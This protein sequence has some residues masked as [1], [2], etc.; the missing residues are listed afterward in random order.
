MDKH[1]SLV[2]NISRSFCPSFNHGFAMSGPFHFCD[3]RK[4]IYCKE[5]PLTSCLYFS[6][7]GSRLHM[8]D[9]SLSNYQNLSRRSGVP[10]PRVDLV[11]VT[12]LYSYSYKPAHQPILYLFMIVNKAAAPIVYS[13]HSLIFHPVS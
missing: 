6:M 10:R 12:L 4:K 3:H 7:F 11:Q 13:H 5:D 1:G 8:M 2:C 9:L